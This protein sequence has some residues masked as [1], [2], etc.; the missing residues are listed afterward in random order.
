MKKIFFKKS[1]KTNNILNS[2]RILFS[3]I[4]NK[5]TE[6]IC[7]KADNDLLFLYTKDYYAD[8]INTKISMKKSTSYLYKYLE[9]KQD[10]YLKEYIFSFIFEI[11]IIVFIILIIVI[12]ILLHYFLS[13]KKICCLSNN[14]KHNQYVKNISLIISISLHLVIILL[15]MIILFNFYSL[16]QILNNSFCSLFKIAYHTYFGEEKNYDIK[17]K[18]IGINEI[19][20]LLQ[21][22]KYQI[23]DIYYKKAEIYHLLT[24]DIKTNFYSDLKNNEFIKNHIT[25]FCDLSKFKV[26]NPNPLSDKNITNFYFCINIL[27]L[28]QKEFNSNNFSKYITDI[29]DIYEKINSI[30]S[31][32]NE[33]NF[34]FDNAKN[35][36]DSFI[37]IIS[38]LEIDYLDTLYYIS[39]EI[40]NK[41]LIIIYYIIFIFVLLI[42]SFGLIC[43]VS[44]IF[45]SNSNYCYKLYMFIWNTQ[46]FTLIL[47]LLIS[48]LFSACSI[49]IQDISIII[50]YSLNNENIKLTKTFSFSKSQYD[51]EGID[52]CINGEGSLK[53]YTQLDSNSESLIHFYS[54]INLIKHNLNYLINY[55]IFV[56][57][58]EAK[59]IFDELKQKPFLAKYLLNENNIGDIL[60]KNITYLSPQSILETHLNKYTNDENNQNIGNN[61][62]FS[63]YMFVHSKEFC[64]SDYNFIDLNIVNTDNN[65]YYQN[66]KFCMLIK[67]FPDN[68][69]FKG[70]RIKNF[71]DI[72]ENINDIN[73]LY[74]LDNLTKEFKNRYYD[75]IS[76]F[77]SSFEKLLSNSQHY[78]NNIIS[79]NYKNIKNAIIKILQIVNDI[80]NIINELY[81]NIIGKNNTNLFTIFN[82]KYLKRDINIFLNQIYNNLSHSL[83]ILSVYNLVIGIFLLLCVIISIFVLKLNKMIKN[84]YESTENHKNG[85]DDND[86]NLSE[87]PKIG[88]F[89][90]KYFYDDIIKT[91]VNEKTGFSQKS[92]KI[93]NN[94]K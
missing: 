39:E 69:Y 40:I 10:D 20:N 63:N 3:G 50:Q 17:P 62:Y 90:E 82:C 68:D 7:G 44:N 56:E 64:K 33:I 87:K 57:K 13:S 93:Q 25:K 61:S 79:P 2:N 18:W 81:E 4:E 11:S 34:S 9:E 6:D 38:D 74:N 16:I 14:K 37:K 23:D 12:W 41:Y 77:K 70:I 71:E 67:D 55:T 88:E 21:K 75:N 73:N 35:K 31:H 91:N 42:N 30:D 72:I 54:Y 85:I 29:D 51:I 22:T 52:I 8:N 66:G 58:N 15:N 47:I 86:I 5:K 19:K 26:P 28:I 46:M 45:C 53:N 27:D 65:S 1:L 49:I 92:K 43:I 76:G 78:Y 94:K 89:H 83:F 80:I 59:L 36:L 60:F 32:R 84:N 24:H 48:I